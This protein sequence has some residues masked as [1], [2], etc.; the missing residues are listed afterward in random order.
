[1]ASAN[2]LS[3]SN[4]ARKQTITSTF[5]FPK[6]EQAVVF[7]I[8]EGINN[9]A[10]MEAITKFVPCSRI[11][12][13]SRMSNGRM[14]MYFDSVDTVDRF[15]QD[16]TEVQIDEQV[17]SPRR[18]INP[19]KKLVLS[20]VC[21]II[22]HDV[23]EKQLIEKTKIKLRSPM[24]FIK[25]GYSREDMTHIL[26]FRRSILFDPEKEE[27]SIPDSLMINYDGEDYR[28]FLTVK[29]KKI[30]TI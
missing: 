2:G 25:A 9:E 17:V 1:M 18:L 15:L 5:K 27:D 16:H 22:P 30:T 7:P 13:A 8:L 28:V 21:P 19:L 11:Q 20:N 23:I 26:S 10:Y 12:F 14:C 4:A 29:N 24:M 3:Y 6:K